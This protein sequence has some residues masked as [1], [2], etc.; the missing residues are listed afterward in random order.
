MLKQMLSFQRRRSHGADWEQ[1][2]QSLWLILSLYFEMSKRQESTARNEESE[3]P[4]HGNGTSKVHARHDNG[5]YPANTIESRMV[6][7]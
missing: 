5:K 6:N 3:N 7:H 2:R 4:H 1:R